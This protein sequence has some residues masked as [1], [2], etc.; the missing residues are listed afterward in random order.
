VAIGLVGL[1]PGYWALVVLAALAGLG[2]S[3]FHP[4]DYSILTARVS[5]ARLGRAYSVHAFAGN[6][7][8][9]AAPVV[10]LALAAQWG[11]RA[12]LG[13]GGLLGCGAVVTLLRQS[14]LAEPVPT[15]AATAGSRPAGRA[16]GPL[17][18]SA[19]ILACFAYFALLAFALIGVQTFLVS[20][21]MSLYATPLSLATGTLT[22]YLMASAAGILAGGRLADLT[23][24]HDLVAA[25]GMAAAAALM[26]IVATGA[27]GVAALVGAIVA[28]GFASGL[29]S[30][31]RDMLIRGATPA[32]ASGRVFGFVYSGLDLGSSAGPL[33]FG[34]LLD[35]DAPRALFLT[36]AAGLALT[37]AT[38]VEVR[39]R[40]PP[41]AVVAP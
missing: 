3:V 13:A 20:A 9:A 16:R 23:R 36:I 40:T 11:W 6:L 12:A 29:T 5:E 28:G 22:A 35:H 1:A 25:S 37:I 26:A 39:R 7:G 19:P 38:V 8:W 2:N 32:G 41:A 21:L 33:L 34:W 30:P 27:L 17:L 15:M 4:A 10:V 18:L 31:S 14:V 24:R